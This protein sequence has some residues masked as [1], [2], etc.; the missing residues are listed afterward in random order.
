MSGDPPKNE[1]VTPTSV[2]LWFILEMLS[3]SYLC[4][5]FSILTSHDYWLIMIASYFWMC[6]W[7]HTVTVTIRSWSMI[8]MIASYLWMCICTYDC[9]IHMNVCMHTAT[10]TTR[11]C[12]MTYECAYVL[13]IASY[14]WF[15]ICTHTTTLTTR[16]C[17]II[18]HDCFMI[19]NVH[20]YTNCNNYNKIH[21]AWAT[22]TSTF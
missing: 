18:Y 2:A 22:A 3:L 11:S 12:S 13:T 8:I 4:D 10:V 20:A 9:F 6:I 19:V 1:K 14:L 7:T 15:C 17:S 21:G 5:E 16:S